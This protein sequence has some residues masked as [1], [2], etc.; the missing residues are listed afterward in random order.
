[1]WLVG[2]TGLF[3]RKLAVGGEW[4]SIPIVEVVMRPPEAFVRSLSHQEAV[5]LKRLSTRAGHQA[6]RLRAA[7][8]LASSP[9]VERKRRV[10][11][12]PSSL[13]Q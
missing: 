10:G 7:I 2:P 3:D 11:G 5:K 9:D 1:M 13:N 8:L 12:R 6:T 4:G